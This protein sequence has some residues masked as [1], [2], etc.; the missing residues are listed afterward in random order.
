MLFPPP[1]A[2]PLRWRTLGSVPGALSI[3]TVSHFEAVCTPP[4]PPPARGVRGDQVTSL[5]SRLP[6]G[7][8]LGTEAGRLREGGGGFPSRFPSRARDPGMLGR[9]PQG[10]E[11]RGGAGGRVAP[12]SDPLKAWGRRAGGQGWVRNG[13]VP[14]CKDPFVRFR[15]GYWD[16]GGVRRGRCDRNKGQKRSEVK[17]TP[18]IMFG[19]GCHGHGRW[20]AGLMM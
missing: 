4:P 6:A 2:L 20:A 14:F 19:L 1:F 3:S 16:T 13:L 9:A 15:R 7:A 12:Q 17:K 10:G 18:E 5:Q 11:K 8:A